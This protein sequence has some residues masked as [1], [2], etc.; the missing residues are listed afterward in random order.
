MIVFAHDPK[1]EHEEYLDMLPLSFNH[2]MFES[3]QSLLESP[4]KMI[5]TSWSENYSWTMTIINTFNNNRAKNCEDDLNDQS[6]TYDNTAE[7][8]GSNWFPVQKDKNQ[9]A[10]EIP[11]YKPIPGKPITRREAKL[12]LKQSLGLCQS[13][14]KSMLLKSNSY[15]VKN[16]ENKKLKDSN[17]TNKL[18]I[19]R[20]KKR[21]AII[22]KRDAY[23]TR[24]D[25]IMKG[26]LRR[27]RKY[28]QEMY[29]VYSQK[30]TNNEGKLEKEILDDWNQ[31]EKESL[32]EFSAQFLD[33]QF[34][35]SDM[36]FYLGKINSISYLFLLIIV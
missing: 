6:Y 3:S 30:S 2:E 31:L 11:L 28:Y 25:V 24:K 19:R 36:V 27:C 12:R 16:A 4:R 5:K 9:N 8:K 14:S 29:V 1:S 32:V 18:S 33:K 23:K 13:N 26:I 10:N 35:H 34:D 17:S 7:N 20:R 21:K 15:S 22:V